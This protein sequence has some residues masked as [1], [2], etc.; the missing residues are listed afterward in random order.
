MNEDFYPGRESNP[1]WS[2]TEKGSSWKGKEILLPSLLICVLREFW[3]V[4]PSEKAQ[5]LTPPVDDIYIFD[6]KV[7]LTPSYCSQHCYLK[8][9]TASISGSYLPRRSWHARF[10]NFHRQ[11][12]P[13]IPPAIIGQ[14]FLIVQ[15]FIRP[16]H[17]H[18]MLWDNKFWRLLT[19]QVLAIFK[20][21]T[22]WI[23]RRQILKFTVRPTVRRR[24]A[25][26]LGR[27]S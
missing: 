12:C 5:G 1:F 23:M 14:D 18:A 11:L 20:L 25:L 13:V 26:P 9:N 16:P 4:Y 7:I 6:L 19:R 15:L 17:R 3:Y 27:Q 24:V 8:V 21:H 10:L 22:N 2:H